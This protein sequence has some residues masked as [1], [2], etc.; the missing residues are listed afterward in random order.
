MVNMASEENIMTSSAKNSKK[1]EIRK[2]VSQDFHNSNNPSMI[3]PMASIH[4]QNARDSTQTLLANENE[5]V[6]S[7]NQFG[8]K[9]S[10]MLVN[11]HYQLPQNLRKKDRAGS[12]SS[13]S[14]RN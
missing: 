10:S 12:N 9:S 11:S 14:E 3:N 13:K 8:A 7:Y 2:L 4:F 5:V 6:S 1:R